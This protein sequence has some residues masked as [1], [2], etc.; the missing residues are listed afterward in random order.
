MPYDGLS[1]Y[2]ISDE[3]NNAVVD[4]RIHK[5]YQ[6]TKYEI[7]LHFSNKEKNALLLCAD[8][9]FPRVHLI[10]D[11]FDNPADRRHRKKSRVC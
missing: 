11:T 7:V 4:Y 9:A 1:T 5:I 10:G 8:P 6:P 2:V 3:L